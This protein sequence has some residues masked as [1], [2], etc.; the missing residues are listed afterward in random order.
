ME[1]SKDSLREETALPLILLAAVLQGWSLYALHHAVKFNHWPATHYAMLIPLCALA[2]FIPITVQLLAAY[3]RAAILWRFLVVLA[4]ALFYFG[5]H[6]GIHVSND[7]PGNPQNVDAYLQLVPLFGVLWLL[8]LPFVQSKL[9]TDQWARQYD[10]LFTHSWHNVLQLGEAALFTG[11]FW[12]LLFLWQMLF[13]LLRIDYFRELFA[14]PIF[15]YPVTAL[16]LG[17][18]IHLIG[19]ITQLT[20]AVL[21]QL[22]N[23]FKWLA[24]LAAVILTFFSIALL[25]SFPSLV[26]AGQ[27]AIGATWLLWLVAGMV[28][29]LNAAYRDGS[30]PQPYPKWVANGLRSVVP[31]L[32]I[33]ALT[34]LY[35]LIV[36]SRYYGLT[37]ERVWA[38]IVAAAGLMYSV[39]YSVAAFQ[40]GA[41]LAAISRVNVYVALF[42]IA[43]ICA[44]LTPVLSPYRL[45]ANSQFRLVQEHGLAAIE[46][47]KTRTTGY[48][49]QNT[50][51]QYLRFDSGQYGRTK[52]KELADSYSGADAV[53]IREEATAM[54]ARKNPYEAITHQDIPGLLGKLQ[55][56][57]AGRTLTKDLSETLSDDL[58]KTGSGFGLVNFAD[59]PA[60]GIYIDL[61]NDQVDDFVF[62]TPYRGR[63]YEDRQGK[64]TYIGDVYLRSADPSKSDI[65]GAKRDLIDDLA[66]GKLSARP[67]KWN[68]LV[69]GKHN[70]QLNSSE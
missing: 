39:G 13:H 41:W 6:F 23:V 56:Y 47:A 20:S 60:V 26:F 61:N 53:R 15:F 40:K 64:W 19:S 38:F 36:R 14:E 62:L 9:T 31:L 51:L 8:V 24:T 32:V 28:L 65:A 33:I 42:L 46:L 17:C 54:L 57:P 45:A 67:S 70:Y 50:P 34:A 22:L 30:V 68:D 16:T 21:E 10:A 29:L 49:M 1:N 48:R 2:V 35:A 27:K 12:L 4:I 18:A 11:L 59:E 5:W 66:R 43:I 52:L 37:V 7:A 69:I 58:G 55:V 63:L 25:L 44:A 3:A